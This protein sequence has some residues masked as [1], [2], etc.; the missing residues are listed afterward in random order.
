L[1]IDRW[2]LISIFSTISTPSILE[3]LML[4][5]LLLPTLLWPLLA[6]TPELPTQNLLCLEANVYFEAGNQA[7]RGKLAV[8][9]VTLNRGGN[10]CKTV[11]ARKQFSWTSQQRWAKIES[12]LLDKPQLNSR[13]AKAWEESKNAALSSEVVLSKEYKFFHATYVSP[14]WTGPGIVIGDHKFL[15]GVK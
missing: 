6:L 11:F 3:K 1:Q 2:E 5:F 7:W 15:K 13:E 10:V 9:D 14:Y 4:N 8:K 12:F